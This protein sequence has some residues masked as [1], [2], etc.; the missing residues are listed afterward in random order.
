MATNLTDDVDIFAPD[1][2][3]LDKAVE[4][5]E[6]NVPLV[7]QIAAGLTLPGMAM[8][9]ATAGKYGKRPAN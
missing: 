9:L 7:G 8:D 6:E 1:K 4:S 2:D 5:Y 3:L